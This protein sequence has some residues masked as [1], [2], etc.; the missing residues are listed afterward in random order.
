M[1]K[2]LFTWVSCLILF[3]TLPMA[4]DQAQ[5]PAAIPDELLD[6]E[7]IREEFGINEFTAPS[8]NKIFSLL[9]RFRPLP[10]DEMKRIIPKDPAP[11]R[12]TV[13][14]TLGFLI[15]DGFFAVEGEQFLDLEPVGLS[16]L[17]HAKAIGAGERIK[18]HTKSI[19]D[20]QNL[21][22]WDSLKASLA[23]T[24]KDIERE[25]VSIRDVDLA[26]LI[27]LGGWLRALEIGCA[28]SLDPYDAEKAALIAQPVIVEYFS[29][30]LEFMVNR[31]P[32]NQA[33]TKI[34][35]LLKEIQ[36]M[37]TLPEQAV[38][39]E[40]QVRALQ[41]KISPLM[42]ELYGKKEEAEE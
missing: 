3:T 14:I 4:Q 17:K 5:G 25:M 15:A 23:K 9:K 8:I 38:L 32:D 29:S 21:R 18:A 12:N 30:N 33:V 37:V 28:A 6:D 27:A 7:H 2:T 40:A 41:A 10:Y 13:A 39:S 26:H 11:D 16:L 20:Q 34:T 22:D 35:A 19:L 24:Q 1:I 31:M 42:D 36:E